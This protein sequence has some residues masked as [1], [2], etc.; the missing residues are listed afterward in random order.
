MVAAVFQSLPRTEPEFH[1][2]FG[3]EEACREYLISLKWPRGF[4]CPACG[5]TQSW[6]R[7]NRDE[8][9][10]SNRNCR[11]ET[12]LRA[13]TLFHNSRKPLKDW[14]LTMFHMVT[15]K[16]GVSA[17]EMQR[18]LG[19]GSN[20]TTLRWL[21]ELRRVM[22]AAIDSRPRLS[23]KI[24]CDEMLIGGRKEGSGLRGWG[25]PGK[26]VIVGAVECR[27]AGSGRA[28]LRVLPSNK[29]KHIKSFVSAMIEPGSM[30][31]ADGAM[32]YRK[33]PGLMSDPIPT[34]NT[35]GKALKGK[36]GKKIVE[37]HLPRIHRVFSLVKR[38]VN[39]CHQ[40]SF[41]HEHIQGYL[42]EYCYRFDGRQNAGNL[43]MLWA[44]AAR[45]VHQRSKTYWESSGR[46]T[47]DIP[48]RVRPKD[49]LE[50]AQVLEAMHG[51]LQED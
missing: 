51:P 35:R 43:K 8:W 9:V 40:G 12:S 50:V 16:Q 1:E 25:D 21:R 41:S 10:C 2:R 3:S 22:G 6:R 23:G 5:G 44:L 11:R 14:F 38:I 42:D 27:G 30:V 29:G 24:E 34:T 7:S 19:Y 46:S 28:R 39:G 47:P 48:T 33:L 45:T 18:R 4:V 37:I 15:S 17:L 13:G 32:V 20:R 36:G 31:F 26:V 49:F